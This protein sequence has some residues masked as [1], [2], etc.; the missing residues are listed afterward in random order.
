MS[1]ETQRVLGISK[2]Y[3]NSGERW[4]Y[5]G[6]PSPSKGGQPA[7]ITYHTEV[8]KNGTTCVAEIFINQAHSEEEVKKIAASVGPAK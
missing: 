4:F 1:D 2:M 3:E 5:A 8:V 7:R 6:N